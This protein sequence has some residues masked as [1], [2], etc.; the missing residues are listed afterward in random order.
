MKLRLVADDGAV[1]DVESLA[2]AG[3]VQVEGV[4]HRVVH[5]GSAFREPV[6]IDESVR[7]RI[8]ELEP[9]AP[10]HN[11]PALAGLAAAERALPDVPHVAVFDSSFHA[12]M[13]EEAAAYALPAAWREKW[14]LRRYGFHGI[15]VAWCA[16]RVPALI[17]RPAAGLRLIVCH[18]GGGCSVTAVR[19][20]RSL[21]TTMGFTPLEGVPMETRSG[22]V[23]PGALIYLLRERGLTV[24]DLDEALNEES[25]LKGLSG[26]SGDVRQLE[27]LAAAGDEP[28]RLALAVYVHRIAA[29][30]GA[31]T[32]A[33]GGLDALAFT[34]GVGEHSADVRAAVCDRLAFLGIEIDAAA[35][36]RAEADTDIAALDSRVRVL[37]VAAREELV[38]AREVRRLLGRGG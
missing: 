38:I 20:G 6:L 24:D 17:G 31:M 13:P 25:G 32:T 8:L 1:A 26:R 29:A 35:N 18:L 2:A 5:G 4:G 9:L 22:S 11:R 28:A 34:A 14:G 21:D 30:I 27:S 19:D 12:T 16:E 33:L 10:L 36:A 15:S 3:S 37:V 7:R 23:D